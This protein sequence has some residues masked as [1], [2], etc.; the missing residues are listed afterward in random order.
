MCLPISEQEARPPE[1]VREFQLLSSLPITNTT[2]STRLTNNT[3]TTTTT[4]TTTNTTTITTTIMVPGH[5]LVS[6]ARV[7]RTWSLNLNQ[8]AVVRVDGPDFEMVELIVVPRGGVSEGDRFGFYR[9]NFVMT[10]GDCV[11]VGVDQINGGD[12]RTEGRD[13]DGVGQ[14][15]GEKGEVDGFEV[16]EC[17]GLFLFDGGVSMSRVIARWSEMVRSVLVRLLMVMPE[18][19][20]RF[21]VE[22]AIGQ[23]KSRWRCLDRSGGMLLYHPEKVCRIVQACGVLHN[24]AHRHGVP[25]HEV[26]APDDPD[27]GP[28]NAQPNAEA[29]RTRQQLI[30]RI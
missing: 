21:I 6:L 19:Q 26:M 3:T 30:A 25:S 11:I 24:I 13:G 5:R 17:Y 4:T 29:I 10:G 18:V 15:G 1:V 12:I 23:L 8:Q 27:P 28:N 16:P 22:R 14:H 2:T 7:R 9:D 20:T